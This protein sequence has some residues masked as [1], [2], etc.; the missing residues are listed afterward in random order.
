MTAEFECDLT[1]DTRQPR[2]RFNFDNGWTGS[3]LVRTGLDKTNALLASVAACPTGR[4]QEG[5]TVIGPTEA[6]ANEAIEWLADI[7]ARPRYE[8]PVDG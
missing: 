6:S 1:P 5:K 2:I 7:A 8:E 3:L 4:W